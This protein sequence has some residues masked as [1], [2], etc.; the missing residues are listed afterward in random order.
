[1]WFLL[2]L[3]LLAVPAKAQ[4][5]TPSAQLF[6]QYQSDYL[7]QYNLYGQAYADYSDKKQIFAKYG[8]VTT[9]NDAFLAAVTAINARSRVFESYL[10]ALRVILDNYRDA[11]PVQTAADQA[12]LSSWES[13]FSD[14]ITVVSAITNTHDLQIWIKTFQGKYNQ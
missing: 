5:S 4:D 3:F 14:Q 2:F 13:W 6:N 7:Y 1:M 9:Q 12:Q 10:M 11:N 8:T